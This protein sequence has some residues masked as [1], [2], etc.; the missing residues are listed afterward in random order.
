MKTLKMLPPLLI[1]SALLIGCGGDANTSESTPS[2]ETTQSSD[3]EGDA[4]ETSGASEDAGTEGDAPCEP[5]VCESN[6]CG[7]IDNGCGLEMDCGE[8]EGGIICGVS[9]IA[10]AQQAA[11]PTS[12]RCTHSVR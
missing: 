4:D 11:L 7:V 10:H 6:A 1:A 9:P 5:K 8:C 2:E 3:S 12:E